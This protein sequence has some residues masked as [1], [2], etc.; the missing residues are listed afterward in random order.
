MNTQK[1]HEF[2]VEAMGKALLYAEENPSSH[3]ILIETLVAT[4][5]KIC[6]MTL[7]NAHYSELMRTKATVEKIMVEMVSA[8]LQ[9]YLDIERL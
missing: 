5:A 2:L 6:K 7:D 4:I 9:D 8:M 3:L 1:D